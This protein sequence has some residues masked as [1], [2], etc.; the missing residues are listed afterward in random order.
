M[1]H[2]GLTGWHSSHDPRENK[3]DEGTVLRKKTK[4]LRNMLMM[5]DRTSRPLEFAP[6]DRGGGNRAQLDFLPP[7]SLG[8]CDML[9]HGVYL[10]DLKT[11]V[12]GSPL[13]S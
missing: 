2:N 8:L 7:S 1:D 6:K 4:Q 12:P 10:E 11:C 3:K 5:L 9:F 13:S